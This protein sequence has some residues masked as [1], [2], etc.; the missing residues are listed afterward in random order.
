MAQSAISRN[1]NPALDLLRVLA[2]AMVLL[3]HAGQAAGLDSVT[4][5]GG[6]GV[7]LFFILSGCLTMASL[8]RQPKPGAYYA[9]RA[10]R[11]LPLY[12]L[13]LAVRFVFDAVGYLASGMPAGRV[14]GPNG[15]CGPRYLRYVFFLQMWLPSE[16]WMLWNNRNALWTMSAFAFFYLLAPWLHRLLEGLGRRF[17]AGRFWG[18]F[19]LLLACLGGKGLLGRAIEQA[20][21][22]LP[23]GSVDNISEFSAKNPPMELYAFLFGV[24]L[25]YAVKEGRGLLYGGFCL[26][27]PM[28]FGFERMAWEGVFTVL[29]LLAVCLPCQVRPGAAGGAFFKLRQLF[30][31]SGPSDAAAV[32]PGVGAGRRAGAVGVSG[33]HPGCLPGSLLPAVRAGGAPVRGAVCPPPVT[34][35]FP[36]FRATPFSCT[37]LHAGGGRFFQRLYLFC[38]SASLPSIKRRQAA[39]TSGRRSATALASSGGNLPSTQAARSYWG[40]GFF[41][42]PMR[43]R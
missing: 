2:A 29:V 30:P 1:P 11:I 26:L 34:Q 23:A 14:F 28:A 12:W 33:G 32:F 8:D 41:P 10:R 36:Y 22:A 37:S 17:A 5:V 15:P 38:A 16:D 4:W 6:N 35:P 24:T 9:G 43:T 20:L 18:S 25:F 7:L 21:N 19:A 13:V 3:V 31:V 40:L 39:S 42:T 27:L